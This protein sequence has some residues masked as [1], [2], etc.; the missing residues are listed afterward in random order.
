M[1][2]KW[3]IFK[4]YFIKKSYPVRGMYVGNTPIDPTMPLTRLLLLKLSSV[5]VYKY[6]SSETL[7]NTE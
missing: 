6:S 3:A 5:R 2:Q 1:T 7:K 4:Q